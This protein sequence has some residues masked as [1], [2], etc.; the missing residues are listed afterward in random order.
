MQDKNK[1]NNNDLLRLVALAPFGLSVFLAP[2]SLGAISMSL[3]HIAL[4]WHIAELSW[5]GYIISSTYLGSSFIS[6]DNLSF[7]SRPLSASSYRVAAVP[8]LFSVLLEHLD[9]L[10]PILEL[11][12]HVLQLL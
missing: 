6:L 7:Q 2:R 1:N 5:G 11:I 9:E 12:K 10:L 8:V 4:S 3:S